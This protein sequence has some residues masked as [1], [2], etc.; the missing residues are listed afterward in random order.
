MLFLFKLVLLL[1]LG[2]VIYSYLKDMG[3]AEE[4]NRY[5]TEEERKGYELEEKIYNLAC[6]NNLKV[7]QNIII[8]N[9]TGKTTE[10]DV[11]ILSKKGFYAIEAKNY[12]GGIAGNKLWKKWTITYDKKRNIKRSFMNPINQNRNHINCLRLMFPR[13]KFE[14]MVVFG[15]HAILSKELRKTFNVKTYKGFEYFMENVLPTKDD[16]LTA[17]EVESVYNFLKRYKD[18][19]RDA[20]IE[21]VTSIQNKNKEKNAK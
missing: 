18:G 6:K 7:L 11:L 1:G 21:F 3:K 17:E 5:K 9:T 4:I 13:F 10:V 20:H 8:P 2:F 12:F 15:E 14:N 19:D 16:S